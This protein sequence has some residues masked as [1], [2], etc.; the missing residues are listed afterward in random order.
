MAPEP[1]A[2]P[3]Q[4]AAECCQRGSHAPGTLSHAGR[5]GGFLPAALHCAGS[6]PSPS[7]D[8]A[9]ELSMQR[10]GEQTATCTRHFKKR[11]KPFLK[12]LF[13]FK[14]LQNIN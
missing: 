1:A 9:W 11:V 7:R 10:Q 2:S 5:D 6:T 13:I 14:F 12:G 3:A 8:G 4:P